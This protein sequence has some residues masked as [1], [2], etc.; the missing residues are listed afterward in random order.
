VPHHGVALPAELQRHYFAPAF[1]G[2]T[3]CKHTVFTIAYPSGAFSVNES[4][5][6]NYN[7]TTQTKKLVEIF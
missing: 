4:E 1:A 6:R 3:K 7:G 2:A 5:G